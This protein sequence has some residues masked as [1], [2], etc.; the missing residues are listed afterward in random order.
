MEIFYIILGAIL[1]VVFDQ[2]FKFG[3]MKYFEF[4]KKIAE[5]IKKQNREPHHFGW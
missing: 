2:L 4:K 1:G 3:K 5:E